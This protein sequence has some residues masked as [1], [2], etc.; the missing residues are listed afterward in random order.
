MG[1]PTLYNYTNLTNDERNITIL[2][3]WPTF[4]KLT[5]KVVMET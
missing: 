3:A 1:F 5:M 2:N 4:R